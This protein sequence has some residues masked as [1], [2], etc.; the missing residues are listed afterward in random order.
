MSA[1]LRRV[2][3]WASRGKKIGT[4]ATLMKEK[5][6]RSY[7]KIGGLDRGR[8]RSEVLTLSATS[9]STLHDLSSPEIHSMPCMC[10]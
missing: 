2:Q 10:G 7:C 5:N 8:R 9:V 6:S 4:L 1:K 3:N